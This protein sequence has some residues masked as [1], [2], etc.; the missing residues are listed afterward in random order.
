MIRWNHCTTK[1]HCT[2]TSFCCSSLNLSDQS[3]IER[4]VLKSPT[5]RKDLSTSLY[6]YINF[7][8]I[9]FEAILLVIYNFRT[10]IYLPGEL[11]LLLLYWDILYP[12]ECFFFLSQSLSLLYYY[13]YPNSILI[14]ICMASFSFYF[15]LFHFLRYVFGATLVNNQ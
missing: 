2:S 15:L 5:M 13:S 4:G 14:S 11:K 10:V 1:C 9:S 7:W 3:R 6:G 8:F 12:W